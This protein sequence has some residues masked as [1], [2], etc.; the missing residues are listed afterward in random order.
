MSHDEPAPRAG[1][2]KAGRSPGGPGGDAPTPVEGHGGSHATAVAAVHG[3]RTMFTLSGAHVFPMYDAAEKEDHG[4]ALLD[5]RHEQ[6][7]AFAAEATGKLTRSPGLAVLT[8]GPGVTN[9][10]SA[11]AQA[12]FSGAPMVVLGGRAPAGRWGTGSLQEFDHV[13]VVA[14]VTVS[15]ETAR[16]TSDIAA[17]THR[18]FTAARTAHRGPAFLDVHM[19]HFFDRCSSV[20][21]GPGRADDGSPAAAPDR[22]PDTDAVDRIADLLVG[23]ERPVLVL[24]SDVWADRGEDAA[25]RCVESL[26]LPV[27][28]NGMGRGIVPA[29]HRLLV[30]KARGTAF[31][32]ADVVLVVG[33]PLDFRL[34]YGVF[35]G[36]EGATPAKVVHIADSPGQLGHHASPAVATAGDLGLVLDAVV[37]AVQRR[38]GAARPDWSTWATTLREKAD[39]THAADLQLLGASAD[40]V[41]PARI[42]GELLPRLA[43]DA[44]VIG[45]GGDFVSYAGKFIEPARPGNWLD[46]G[47]FGC[48][49]AGLGA[50]IAARIARPSSQV[51]L[52][53]GDGA[54]GFSLIDVDTLV[55]HRLP[56]VMVMGNNG[57]WGLERGPMQMLYGY[58]VIADLAPRTR[59]DEVVKALGGAGEMVTDPAQIG[60]ALD[61]AFASGVPYLVNVITDVE[62]MYPRSTFGV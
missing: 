39:A 48:L 16:D 27:I 25:L 35:G 46:P 11:L 61:R 8:A 14:P 59:Y 36:K 44:V 53:L 5:V 17:A 42:Y 54:A 9:G 47:P 32:A 28:P 24:G 60:P 34:G 52:L 57:A 3:V 40:P 20:R 13:P 56:V 15:A 23:A 26:G 51:V 6:T 1:H 41:H 43:E 37:E 62:A 55:R 31:G 22:S 58:D 2:E 4:V 33:T 29:G 30:T 10:V 38:S 49:G 18:A 21:P 45:D 50:A 19:D 7:A 12:S